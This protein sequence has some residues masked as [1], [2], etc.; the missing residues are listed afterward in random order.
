MGLTGKTWLLITIKQVE[1]CLLRV[2]SLNIRWYKLNGN[3]E[4]KGL[5]ATADLTKSFNG[6]EGVVLKSSTAKTQVLELI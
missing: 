1:H 6:F 3:V 2:C 4:L 5:S